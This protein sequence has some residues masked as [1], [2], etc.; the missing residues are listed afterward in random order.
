MSVKPGELRA[1][2]MSDI[3]CRKKSLNCAAIKP[4]EE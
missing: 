3:F 4:G 2:R 1:E